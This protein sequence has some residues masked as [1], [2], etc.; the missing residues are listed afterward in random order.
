MTK[1]FK[2]LLAISYALILF[3]FLYLIFSNIQISRINDFS[4][5]KEIQFTIEA[6][7]GKNIYINLEHTKF[8]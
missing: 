5:Y 6:F 3:V 7:I 8:T 4:Y 1:N 2:I